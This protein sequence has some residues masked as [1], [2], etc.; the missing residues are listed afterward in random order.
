M[1]GVVVG[2]VPEGC[3]V[4]S[5]LPRVELPFSCCMFVVPIVGSILF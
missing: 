4:K 2:D 3:P 5:Q 1:V